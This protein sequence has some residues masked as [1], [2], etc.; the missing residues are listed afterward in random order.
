VVPTPTTE[1]LPT[2]TPPS[3]FNPGPPPPPL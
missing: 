2:L 1:S 3:S